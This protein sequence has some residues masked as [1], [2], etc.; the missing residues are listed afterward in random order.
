MS[1]IVKQRVHRLLQ[2]AFL[3][4]DDDLRGLERQQV[5]QSVVAVDDTA[6][7]VVQVGRGKT[8]AFERNQ[9]AQIRWD[10]RQHRQHHPLR[11]ALGL[12]EPLVNLD[13]LGQFLA[14][15]LA[16]RL[17]HGELQL[18][19]TRLE[20]DGGQGVVHS[21]GTNLGHEGVRPVGF[22]G[23]AKLHFREELVF[24]QRRVAGIHHE[25]IL[26]VDDSL[27]VSRGDIHHQADAGGHALEKPN[28][29]HRHGQLDVPHALAPHARLRH[30]NAATV[31]DH[32]AMLDALVLAAG[33]LP[34]LD[35]AEDA[36]AKKPALLRLECPVVDGLGVLDLTLGP[37]AD[38]LRGSHRD[39]D[40][41]HVVD[42]VESE[43]L[44]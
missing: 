32:A 41:L 25:I 15:L 1:T 27:K 18:I 17:G 6:I 4:P 16:A 37:R 10:H 26:V 33:A 42:P 20:V 21:L 23:I 43:Q 36:L 31:A 35:R 24:F 44:S 30:L 19:N 38:G 22:L 5:L 28:V 7:Q 12:D 29:G 40:G 34:V 13:A 8:A 11:A 9:G 39:G 2:H 3:I 14:N